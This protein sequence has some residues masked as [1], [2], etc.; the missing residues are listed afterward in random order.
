[1]VATE[2]P[3][4]SLPKRDSLSAERHSALPAVSRECGNTGSAQVSPASAIATTAA[5]DRLPAESRLR[6]QALLEQKAKRE[7]INI[8]AADKSIA[9]Q[10]MLRVHGEGASVHHISKIN[11]C[12]AT[13]VDPGAQVSASSDFDLEECITVIDPSDRVD[14]KSFSGNREQLLCLG[15]TTKQKIC[16][17]TAG[18]LTCFVWKSYILKTNTSINIMSIHELEAAGGSAHFGTNDELR[19]KQTVS[20]MQFEHVYNN[21]EAI[22]I[23]PL[24]GGVEM[25]KK[26]RLHYL[27]S[28]SPALYDSRQ[29]EINSLLE[30]VHEVY[31]YVGRAAIAQSYSVALEQAIG[32]HQDAVAV[33]A[34]SSHRFLPTFPP[35]LSL[36][37]AH[38]SP[39]SITNPV[40]QLRDS[41]ARVQ[42]HVARLDGD[43]H[44][45][46]RDFLIQQI[47]NA[48]QEL[49]EISPT[50]HSIANLRIGTNS[51]VQPATRITLEFTGTELTDTAGPAPFVAPFTEP[52]AETDNISGTDEFHASEE[53][54]EY[55]TATRTPAS[56]QKAGM[57][58]PGGLSMVVIQ[59][60]TKLALFALVCLTVFPDATVDVFS[61]ATAAEIYNCVPLAQRHR[62]FLHCLNPRTLTLTTM[63]LALQDHDRSCRHV[64][65]LHVEDLDPGYSHVDYQLIVQRLIEFNPDLLCTFRN[66][67]EDRT[68]GSKLNGSM[69]YLVEH[70]V[71][72]H[73]VQIVPC[74]RQGN[75]DKSL[76]DQDSTQLN[77]AETVLELFDDYITG[78]YN[79]PLCVGLFLDPDFAEIAF[80]NL[81]ATELAEG[82]SSTTGPGAVTSSGGKPSSTAA[83]IAKLESRGSRGFR[84]YPRG[85]RPSTTTRKPGLRLVFIKTMGLEMLKNPG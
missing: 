75:R 48:T 37:D 7:S 54:A 36:F 12:P 62:L 23:S 6:R 79:V 74:E 53:T 34:L 56:I 16:Q 40:M 25:V 41:F 80:N 61:N 68:L 63:Q 14:L 18:A 52:Y 82:N 81:D 29:A 33:S 35:D 42:A 45:E 4:L 51:N 26:Q 31:K 13:L 66:K 57:F 47:E 77:W 38:D 21:G 55:S 72:I 84:E 15:S 28:F 1:M 44:Q 76:L 83:R 65:L 69:R 59:T 19:I 30:D 2:L 11:G 39:D 22:L 3:F 50:L 78:K 24:G 9:L 10:N 70:P 85:C 71:A 60:G 73:R 58:S 43:E 49:A 5:W 32:R 17:T 64:D 67:F 20:G 46:Q 27:L 8:L